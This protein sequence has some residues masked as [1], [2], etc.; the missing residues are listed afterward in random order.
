MK[1]EMPFICSR[2]KGAEPTRREEGPEPHTPP[3][4]VKGMQSAEIRGSSGSMGMGKQGALLEHWE[5]HMAP[6]VK[7]ESAGLP[8]ARSRSW[9]RNCP[10]WGVNGHTIC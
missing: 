7:E 9:S 8:G 1:E 2:W 6:D 10:N 3:D 5:S 4:L